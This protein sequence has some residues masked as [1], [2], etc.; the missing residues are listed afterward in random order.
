MTGLE[1]FIEA[2][3]PVYTQVC[4]ELAIGKKAS[5]W[6]WFIFPQLRA[7]GRSKTAQHFGIENLDEAR[8]YWSHPVLGPRLK[9]C[10]ELILAV[11]GKSAH[12]ILGTPDDLKLRSCM[13][14]FERAAPDQAVFPQVLERYCGS[15]RDEHTLALISSP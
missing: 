11:P 9:Q 15:A 10:C 8:A 5:H 7:L 14:L 1:R 13:T 12:D 6:M 2:Q 3:S 4:A